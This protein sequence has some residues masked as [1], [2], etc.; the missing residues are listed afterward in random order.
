MR[1]IVTAGILTVFIEM[2]LLIII[3]NLIGVINTL[4]VVFLTSVLG[5]YIVM[6]KG[7]QS[8]QNVRNSFVNGMAPGPAMVDTMMIYLG[9]VLLITPGF[10]TD[11]IGIL[12]LFSLT[13]KLFKPLVYM[14][15][16][17]KLKSGNMIIVQRYE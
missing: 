12:L 3:G 13:R 14:W 10:L 2:A 16:R 8:I 17:R 5:V 1:K 6:R 9:G 7:A 15:I 11:V 4:F